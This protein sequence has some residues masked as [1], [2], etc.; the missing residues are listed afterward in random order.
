VAPA[1]SSPLDILPG[2]L[3]GAVRAIG[4][5]VRP[6]VPSPVARR[7]ATP[8]RTIM[9]ARGLWEEVEELQVTVLRK[10]TVR[11]A[12]DEVEESAPEPEATPAPVPRPSVTRA[13]ADVLAPR[14]AT[15]AA[16]ELL[17]GD[18]DTDT[19]VTGR[20]QRELGR[21][22]RALAGRGRRALPPAD[23]D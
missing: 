7:A 10:R 16:A 11:V 18:T 3:P 20:T 13:H 8:A 12:N 9:V 21:G 5:L 14:S 19:E 2:P 1:P 4:G 17:D 15:R 22:R 23:E 6:L